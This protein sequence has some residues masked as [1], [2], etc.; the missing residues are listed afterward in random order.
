M[1]AFAGVFIGDILTPLGLAVWI[2]Y[3]VPIIISFV[4]WRPLTPPILAGAT[5]VFLVLGFFMSPP[6]VD[7]HLAVTNR[8][9]GGLTAWSMGAAGYL[10]IRAKRA[11]RRQEWF[12]AAQV[13]LSERMGGELTLTQ[14]GDNALRYIAEY[15]GAQAAAIFV[16]DGHSF[17]RCASYAVPSG[18]GIPDEIG[19]GDGLLGQALKD[20]RRLLLRDVPEGYLYFGSSLG[21]D[22]PRNLLVVP[23]KADDEIIA[24]IELGFAGEVGEMHVE[25]V[26]RV[27]QA[28]G[29]AVRSSKYRTRLQELLEETKRQAE[30]LQKQGEE[31]RASNEELEEQSR[32]LEASQARLEQQQVE[33]EQTNAELEEQT[34][35]LEAQ[36]A[37]LERSQAAL[38]TQARELEQASRYKSEFLANMSHELRTPL[39][40]SLIMARLLADNREGN[41]SPEQVRYAETIEASGNDLLSLINDILD[42]SKIEAGRVE[43]HAEPVIVA[44][45]VEKLARTFQPVAHERGLRF[46]TEVG[47]DAPELVETDAQRIEQVLKNFLS[48]AFKFTEGGEVALYVGKAPDGR[49]TFSVRDTGIGIKPEQRQVIFEAFRQADGTTN[50]KYG[51]TGLGLSISRELARLLGGEIDL[52]SDV[53]HGSTFTLLIPPSYDPAQVRPRGEGASDWGSARISADASSPSIIKKP[54]APPAPAAR[55][56][57]VE[58]DREALTGDSRVI[59]VVEDDPSFARILYDLAREQGFQC[60]IAETADEGVAMARQFL[61]HAVVLDM[62][63]PDH[64]GLSVLDRLKHNVSTR[65]I[66][67]HVVSAHDYTQ[68]ALSLG[69][70][71]YLLKPAKR[72]Q[73]VEAFQSLEQRLDR[74]VRR[75]LVVEDDFNQLESLRLLLKA[76]DVETVGATSASECLRHLEQTT[77]DC[78]VLDLTLPDISG[79]DLLDELS[80]DETRA[81]PPVIV[82]TGK[83]LSPDEELRLRRYSKSIIVKGAKSPERLLDEVT[84]FLHQV[85]SDLPGE[86]QRALAQAMN[87]DSALEGRRIL[88]VEDDVR[89]I[90]AVTSIFEPHG[91]FV[92][93][94][95]NGREALEALERSKSTDQAID[96]VLMDMMM[97]EMDGLTAT[98][99]IREKLEWKGL[100]V[101][102]LTAKA[103]PDDQ[104]QCLAAG[105]NDYMAKPLDVEKLLSL[106]R[107]WMP[108]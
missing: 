13:G 10:F 92:Q 75:V 39:N 46:R 81:F 86:Q 22:R 83:D 105:A 78:M 3:L 11:V 26:D 37:D 87:R 16:R 101:I 36:R 108:R 47:V 80:R 45:L 96:L 30:E 19:L 73:L 55:S 18:S 33:L 71:G 27:S 54:S 31:L 7:T 74:K 1:V 93:I 104:E 6:G 65:H 50:R 5:T 28:I 8:I 100:P 14:L 56:S 29:V 76:N 64:T 84:L 94:A 40:S 106:A 20:G 79:F 103:M 62:H 95:R 88:V 24:A 25:M 102:A 58:D 97:P 42:L 61:P 52:V 91:A 43:V 69:A 32:V 68:T 23:I 21:R 90:F 17:R 44:R 34:H 85:V 67:V 2:L 53:G 82:Y 70:I 38:R 89:N 72:G 98:R 15:L 51:G 4:L 60:L 41:L 63:L 12:Q 99:R 59:L 77:F 66:P 57:V 107:V 9:C 49:V 35:L 48:N